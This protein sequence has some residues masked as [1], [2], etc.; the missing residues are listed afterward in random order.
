[1]TTTTNAGR[2]IA[3]A[4]VLTCATGANAD[5]KALTQALEACRA[6][7]AEYCSKTTP[8]NGRVIACL[9]AHEDQLSLKCDYVLFD[10]SAELQN[11][12]GDMHEVGKACK[13]DIELL[14]T[15]VEKGEGRLLHC[16]KQKQKALSVPC[17][18][19]IEDSGIDVK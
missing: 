1:M 13:P 7:V 16:L 14:C 5:D 3:M 12:M 17:A 18:D 15:G 10:A 19:A 8:G 9:Y 4:V 6:E 2:A 11:I